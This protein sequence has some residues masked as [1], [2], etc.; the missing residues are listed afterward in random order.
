M[1]KPNLSGFR[2]PVLVAR[3]DEKLAV[4]WGLPRVVADAEFRALIWHYPNSRHDAS[5]CLF[6]QSRRGRTGQ[7]S[8][9]GAAPKRNRLY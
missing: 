7:I 8:S 9:S 2:F 6:G 1:Q 5:C 4:M 3:S